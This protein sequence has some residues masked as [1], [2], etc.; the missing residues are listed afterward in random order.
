MKKKKNFLIYLYAVSCLF[1]AKCDTV[2]NFSRCYCKRERE[3]VLSV[4]I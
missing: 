1:G 4:C 3:T 2:I